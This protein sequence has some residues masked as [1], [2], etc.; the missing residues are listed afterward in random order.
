MKIPEPN[1][2]AWHIYHATTALIILI[3]LP[4]LT[5]WY[6]VVIFIAIAAVIATVA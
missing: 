5:G 1:T 6:S 3:G 2:I 4:W